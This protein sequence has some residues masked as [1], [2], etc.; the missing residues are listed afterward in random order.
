MFVGK[1]LWRSLYW[2]CFSFESFATRYKLQKTS[3]KLISV[4]ISSISAGSGII[5]FPESGCNRMVVGFTTTYN[6]CPSLLMMC[7]RLLLKARSTTLCDKVCQWP[8]TGRWSECKDR[9]LWVEIVDMPEGMLYSYA[10]CTC[11][12]TIWLTQIF[13]AMNLTLTTYLG[14]NCIAF[15]N[16]TASIGDLMVAHRVYCPF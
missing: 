8:Q 4:S 14:D 3:L 9:Q 13:P 2:K 10:E 5:I 6:L 7:V 11:L 12:E 16:F 15:E 1:A